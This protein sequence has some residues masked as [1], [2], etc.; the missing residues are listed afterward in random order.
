MRIRSAA[1]TSGALICMLA[2]AA[3]CSSTPP[4]SQNPGE[5][6]MEPW[7][8]ASNTSMPASPEELDRRYSVLRGA[9]PDVFDGRFLTASGQMVVLMIRESPTD[10]SGASRMGLVPRRTDVG[11]TAL[12]KVQDDLESTWKKNSDPAILS[13]GLALQD[14]C[15]AVRYDPNVPSSWVASLKAKSHVCV[16]ATTSTL[17]KE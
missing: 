16:I 3:G 6:V 4:K 8:T 14:G 1:F 5:T 9:S 10:F 12:K 11:E 7:F 2:L 15:V 17:A 13:I